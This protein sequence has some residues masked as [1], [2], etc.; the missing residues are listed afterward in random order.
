MSQSQKPSFIRDDPEFFLQEQQ[1]GSP[2]VINYDCV[3][4][5]MQ[6]FERM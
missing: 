2:Y 4:V 3:D 6:W 1:T 5:S